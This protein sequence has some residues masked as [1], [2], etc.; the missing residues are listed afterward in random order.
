MVM[1]NMARW[2]PAFIK[3]RNTKSALLLRLDIV[4]KQKYAWHLCSKI[5]L[6]LHGPKQNFKR[7]FVTNITIEMMGAENICK[8]KLE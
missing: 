6:K 4:S 1:L 8:I 7:N 5:K 3:R 2:V